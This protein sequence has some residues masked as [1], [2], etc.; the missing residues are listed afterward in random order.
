HGAGGQTIFNDTSTAA[1]ASIDNGGS[2]PASTAGSALTIFNDASTAGHA[3]ITNDGR[4]FAGGTIFNDSSTGG[5]VRVKVFDNGYLD[6]SGHQ[7]NLTV[8]SIEGSG[9][10]FLGANDLSVGTRNINTSFSG[11]F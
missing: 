6:I 4:D 2:G 9:N 5:T 8:G 1:N 7:S 11:V 10:V 3:T